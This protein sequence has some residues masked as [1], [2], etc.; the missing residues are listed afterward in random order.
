MVITWK[1]NSIDLRLA[2]LNKEY[3]RLAGFVKEAENIKEFKSVTEANKHKKKVN[4]YAMELAYNIKKKIQLEELNIIPA[5]YKQMIEFV[6]DKQQEI[7]TGISRLQI[8]KEKYSSQLHTIKEKVI[9]IEKKHLEIFGLPKEQETPMRHLQQEQVEPGICL[10]ETKFDSIRWLKQE[11]ARSAQQLQQEQVKNT[12]SLQQEIE[13][14]LHTLY[15]GFV[16]ITRE[17]QQKNTE[18]SLRFSQRI[19]RN[20]LEEDQVEISHLKLCYAE[21]TRL[22]QQEQTESSL[23][24]QQQQGPTTYLQQGQEALATRLQQDERTSIHLPHEQSHAMRRKISSSPAWCKHQNQVGQ[25]IC[26]LHELIGPV[27]GLHHERCIPAIRLMLDAFR[28]LNH[29]HQE[30]RGEAR[31]QQDEAEQMTCLQRMQA[32]LEKILQELQESQRMHLHQEQ[33]GQVLFQ[34]EKA[35]FPPLLEQEVTQSTQFLQKEQAELAVSLQQEQVEMQICLQQEQTGE[36]MRFMQNREVLFKWVEEE[37]PQTVQKLQQDQ[38]GSEIQLEQPGAAM[39]LDQEQAGSIMCLQ[40]EHAELAP[41]IE[42]P[43]LWLP[44]ELTGSAISLQK[45]QVGTE[46]HIQQTPESWDQC[47]QQEQ[48]EN[49]RRL[50]QSKEQSA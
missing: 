3:T 29:L 16:K 8:A 41:W 28:S 40:Q 34:H 43:T 22:L 36:A 15:Q 42:Q 13:H 48:V 2:F 1:L 46:I 5:I 4:D 39:C 7:R 33:S 32:E 10:K 38:A 26:S 21:I 12:H 44:Q 30:S 37:L 18:V 19:G 14:A 9:E 20:A 47:L 6:R 50:E 17:V 27:L 24:I 11:L 23:H 31:L 35:E 49:A 45:E 25:A